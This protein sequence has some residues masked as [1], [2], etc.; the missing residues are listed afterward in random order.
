M[1]ERPTDPLIDIQDLSRE[2][3]VPV[4]TIRNKLSNRTWPLPPIRVGRSPRWLQSDVERFKRGG[5]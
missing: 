4:K 2:V 5:K 1:P 3:K